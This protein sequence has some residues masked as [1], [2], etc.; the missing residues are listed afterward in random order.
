VVRALAGRVPVV[1]HSP[2]VI[3]LAARPD[4]M[5]FPGHARSRR[6]TLSCSSPFRK[7]KVFPP[8]DRR[9]TAGRPLVRE[10]L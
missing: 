4:G 8:E 6:K 1:S 2:R 3:R 5:A 9:K 7:E 10:I